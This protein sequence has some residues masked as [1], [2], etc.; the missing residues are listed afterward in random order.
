M[1][2]SKSRATTT[3]APRVLS[4]GMERLGNGKY[5]IN[6]VE[7]EAKSAKEAVSKQKRMSSGGSAPVGSKPGPSI[8]STKF[9]DPKSVAN[10]QQ[11]EAQDTALYNAYLA[12]PNQT[13]PFG[14]STTSIDPVTGQVTYNS[15]F[16][17]Q[18]ASLYNAEA[19]ADTMGAQMAQSYLKGLPQSPY[20]ANS[21]NDKYGIP[22]VDSEYQNRFNDAAYAGLTRGLEEQ[23]AKAKDAKMQELVNRGIPQ[24]SKQFQDE[25]NMAVEEPFNTQRLQARNSSYQAGLTAGNVNF[26]Q[27]LAANQQAVSNLQSNY[28]MGT[29]LAGAL[30]GMGQG[31]QAPGTQY[32][33][34]QK[35]A[36]DY[37]G[38]GQTAAQQDQ[39]NKDRASAERIA[40][41]NNARRG[42]GGGAPASTGPSFI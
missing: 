13:N 11:K 25:L 17:G 6:G 22:Q 20:D 27:G 36:V 2:P 38:F 9:T 40:R 1:A 16:S 32:N 4:R 10:L 14:S 39:A 21:V 23:Y 7:V 29:N 42:G 34:T 28:N 26:E 19:G 33:A 24:G 18:N 31:Y 12:N 30:T 8:E 3:G 41:M 37:S 5:K 35:N 15:Q